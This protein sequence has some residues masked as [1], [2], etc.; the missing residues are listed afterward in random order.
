MWILLAGSYCVR[1]LT[2]SNAE[3]IIFNTTFFQ[4]L[5]FDSNFLHLSL[6]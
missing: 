2:N 6:V 3:M 1:K 4:I 5:T